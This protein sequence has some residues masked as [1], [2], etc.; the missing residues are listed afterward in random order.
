[1]DEIREDAAGI[2]KIGLLDEVLDLAMK[3][4]LAEEL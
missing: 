2:S 1:M 3:T 4:K